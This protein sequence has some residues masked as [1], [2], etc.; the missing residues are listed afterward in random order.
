MA[1]TP[2]PAATPGRGSDGEGHLPWLYAALAGNVHP[3]PGAGRETTPL[4][5]RCKITSRL[6]LHDER[7]A[8]W[9]V[10]LGHCA[11]FV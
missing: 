2:F 5:K 4:T 11:G 9:C 3:R 10:W 6:T 8:E 7:G 1:P